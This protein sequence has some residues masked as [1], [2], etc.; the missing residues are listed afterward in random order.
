M[1][2]KFKI[3][4]SAKVWSRSFRPTIN[5]KARESSSGLRS[6]NIHLYF[7]GWRG[8]I[9]VLHCR[10]FYFSILCTVFVF[11]FFLFCS[12]GAF[13]DLLLRKK[14]IRHAYIYVFFFWFPPSYKVYGINFMGVSIKKKFFY[15]F[16]L[17]SNLHSRFLGKIFL[18]S[19]LCIK[20]VRKKFNK[21][22]KWV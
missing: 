19:L 3:Y 14:I 2:P 5:S 10:K 17:Q 8:E 18:L 22:S 11:F 9:S 16:S 13:R 4:K 6:D 7:R 1:Q 15:D 21:N 12:L 20:I